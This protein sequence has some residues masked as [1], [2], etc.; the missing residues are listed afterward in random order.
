MHL[1]RKNSPMEIEPIEPKKLTM[2]MHFKRK[3]SPLEIEPIER[4]N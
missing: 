4:K 1:N 3:N 2:E